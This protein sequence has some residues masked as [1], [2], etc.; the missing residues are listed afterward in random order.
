MFIEIIRRVLFS[1]CGLIPSFVSE[2]RGRIVNIFFEK[3]T[4]ILS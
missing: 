1:G 3:I 4:H 2:N